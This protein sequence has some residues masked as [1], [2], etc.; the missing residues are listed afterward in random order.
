MQVFRDDL[1]FENEVRRIARLLWPSAQYGGAQLEDGRERDGVFESEE[2]VHIIECTVSR[3]KQKAVEDLDKLQK[4]TK[5]IGARHPNKFVKG[6]FITLNEPTADQRSVFQKVQG[7]I[8]ALSFDQFRSRLVDARSYLAARDNYPFG[9]VR[10][11]ESGAARFNL[12]YVPLDLLSEDGTQHDASKITEDVLSGHRT[13]LLGDYGA[14]KSAT[15]R[16]LYVHLAIRFRTDK[17]LVFPVLLNL[18]DHHGQ[19]DPVEA[20]ERHARRVGFGPPESLVRAWRA[21]FVSLLLDGFDEIA[22]AGWAGKTKQLKD[23]RYKSM[24]L[25]RAFL[26]DTPNS[27]GIVISGRAHFFDSPREMKLALSLNSAFRTFV[28]SEFSDQ[29]VAEFLKRIGWTEAVPSWVPSR[30]LLLDYLASRRLL[31]ETLR[32]EAGSSPAAGWD[33]LLERICSREAEIEAGIDAGTVRRLIEHLAT[34]ARA[35]ADGLGPLSPDQITAAFSAVCG[36]PPDDRGAV[37]LQRL[38]GLGGHSAED[39]SR[40]FIDQD[41][42]AAAQG[43]AIHSYIEKPFGVRLDTEGWQSALPQLGVEVAAFRCAV[44]GFSSGKLGAALRH[45][46]DAFRFHTLAADVALILSALGIDC[47]GAKV[48]IREVLVPELHIDDAGADLSSIEFQDSI[49]GLLELAPNCSHPPMFIRCYFS[50]VEGRTGE[51]DLPGTF[52]VDPTVETF[53]NPAQTTNAILGLALPLGTKVV[54]TILKKLYAQR[55]SG[56]RESAFFKGLD[57]RAQQLV[58]EALSLLR[59]ESFATRTRQGDQIVWLPAKSSEIRKRALG[60]LAASSA[61]VDP[62]LT[63]SRTIG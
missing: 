25:I 27:A 58:P 35:S 63:E 41:F 29:Q 34:V 18:R 4:L 62:L 48:F 54:L 60:M 28:L 1:A 42:A 59:R 36:Y 55:G 20:I 52:F 38:P 51:Q 53:D 15:M 24:E 21:G 43:G 23:L 9:S 49:F 31:H 14:G 22:T 12:N 26:R 6:W 2:F 8:V 56:R 44:S 5:R 40:V 19:T 13:I 17:S 30:P 10:D 16:E 45:A 47:S 37:L 11:P 46:A 7:R 39:G 33:A 50:V 57:L 61:S 3:S 32:V